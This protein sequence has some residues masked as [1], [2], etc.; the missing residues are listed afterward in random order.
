VRTRKRT[1]RKR[2]GRTKIDGVESVTA[3]YFEG[4]KPERIDWVWMVE[5][6]RRATPGGDPEAFAQVR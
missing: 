4:M 6:K 1:N 2:K 5:A 3:R